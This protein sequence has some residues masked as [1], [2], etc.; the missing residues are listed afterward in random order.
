MLAGTQKDSASRKIR[1]E[2]SIYI[3]KQETPKQFFSFTE[4]PTPKSQNN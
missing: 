4:E 3:K 1:E 2:E